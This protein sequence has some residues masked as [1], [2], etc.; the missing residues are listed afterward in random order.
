MEITVILVRTK[1]PG[2]IGAVARSMSNFDMDK[3][4]LVDPICVDQEARNRA[5][6]A[7][8]ILDN[9][10]WVKTLDEAIMH[11]DIN[12][13]TTGIINT[14]QTGH[15]R[16]PLT[17]DQLFE[18][19]KDGKGKLGLVFGREDTGLLNEELMK[20]DMLL[21]IPTS[22][23][24]PIMNL[25]HA[26]SIVLWDFFRRENTPRKYIEKLR[27]T[28]SLER[29]KLIDT[30]G[31]LMDSIR[32]PPHRRDNTLI[33]FR[34]MI[35]RSV[36]TKWEFHTLMGVLSGAVRKI[37]RENVDNVDFWETSPDDPPQTREK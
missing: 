4:I 24:Y 30:F 31:E 5:K 15:I 6:H 1:Y 20:M 21:S 25:S 29:E 37:R 33:L 26:V 14:R 7:N 13:G 23:E 16:N 3:L 12:V 9:A 18:R 36:P 19:V 11:T 32:Y 2:N 8:Y 34:R 22:K 10:Q 28:S 17:P 27:D 35:G